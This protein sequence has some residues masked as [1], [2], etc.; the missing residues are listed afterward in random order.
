MA[1]QAPLEWSLQLFCL[2]TQLPSEPTFPLCMDSLPSEAVEIAVMAVTCSL[3]MR[4]DHTRR[5][6]QMQHR[7]NP[8]HTL[9]M[10]KNQGS[11]QSTALIAISAIVAG[12]ANMKGYAKLCR[13]ILWSDSCASKKSSPQGL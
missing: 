10:H 7:P 11:Q 8:T 12:V 2:H 3:R 1:R 6:Q 5:L 13:W 4:K 9:Q